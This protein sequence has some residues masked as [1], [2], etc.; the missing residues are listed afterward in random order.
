MQ[1]SFHKYQGLG[2]DFI[3]LK[4]TDLPP[5][6]D[7]S[8]LAQ[9]LCNRH[10]GIGAD[11]LLIQ[12][13]HPE[14]DAR[15]QVINADGSEPEMCGNGL[16]CF[17]SYLYQI[18]GLQ[19]SDYT[20]ATGAGYLSVNYDPEQK[21]VRVNMGKPQLQQEKIPAQ[22][23]KTEQVIQQSLQVGKRNFEVT[24]VSMGNPHCVIAIDAD[25]GSAETQYWGPQIENHPNFPQRTNVEFCHFET[26]QQARI[27]VWERGSGETL[28]CGTGACATLVAGV[29]IKSLERQAAIDLP[30][31]RL[32]IDWDSESNQIS[33]EG[34]A[35]FVFSGSYEQ[36]GSVE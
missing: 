35:H 22:G 29:L 36:E 1:I 4:S 5:G 31:G 3:L 2:N 16:R 33:M 8:H 6:L 19:K 24:L 28:A 25:W 11:G 34:P 17:T 15:M 26:P 12:Y 10:F 32:E 9:K 14:A 27:H 7:L 23:W 21:W 30:G 13:P 18:Q 20:I